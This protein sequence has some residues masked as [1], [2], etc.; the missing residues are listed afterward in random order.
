MKLTGDAGFVPTLY[1]FLGCGSGEEFCIRTLLP[2][3]DLAETVAADVE[4]AP[5]VDEQPVEFLAVLRYRL[6]AQTASDLIVFY[7]AIKIAIARYC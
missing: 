6:F 7:H 2:G 1:E 3:D 5:L 4:L